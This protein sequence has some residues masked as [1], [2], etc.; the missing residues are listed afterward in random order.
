MTTSE[1]IAA[2]D[3]ESDGDNVVIKMAATGNPDFLVVPADVIPRIRF[4][5]VKS[6]RDTVKKHQLKVHKDLQAT[7]FC[8]EVLRIRTEQETVASYEK[9]MAGEGDR[10]LASFNKWEEVHGR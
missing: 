10:Q 5:E 7:G 4:V 3:L 9:W 2:S 1:T 6:G 8:V